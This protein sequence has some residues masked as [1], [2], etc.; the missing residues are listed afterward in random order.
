MDTTI[1]IESSKQADIQDWCTPVLDD[2]KI[3]F[4]LNKVHNIIVF[5]LLI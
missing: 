3:M 4:A 2:S 5:H 1:K